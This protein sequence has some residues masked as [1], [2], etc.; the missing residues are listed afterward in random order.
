MKLEQRLSEVINKIKG[1]LPVVKTGNPCFYYKERVAQWLDNPSSG[2]PVKLL[3]Y[4]EY[5]LTKG[6]IEVY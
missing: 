1:N 5:C 3:N 6:Q 2:D 4:F